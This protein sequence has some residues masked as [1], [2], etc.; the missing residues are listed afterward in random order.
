MKIRSAPKVNPLGVSRRRVER[1]EQTRAPIAQCST[2][3]HSNEDFP[4]DL[5]EG[6]PK[7]PNPLRSRA[8]DRDRRRYY[9]FHHDY[10]HDTEECYDLKNQIKDLIHHDH[11]DRY[12]REPCELSLHPKGLVEWHINVIVGGPTAGGISSSARKTYARAKLQIEHL[13]PNMARYLSEARRLI[14]TTKYFKIFQIPCLE[15]VRADALA[16]AAFANG[17]DKLP[18]IPSLCKPTVAIVEAAT[19]AAHPNWREEI[20]RYKNT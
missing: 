15:N 10:G 1:G 13:E 11:L 2:Q 17:A 7:T 4:P 3:L 9:R 12:I 14:G 6:T 8:E 16:Q 5:R 20:L 19:T 18:T